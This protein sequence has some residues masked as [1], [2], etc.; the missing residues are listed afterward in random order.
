[1]T[2]R[3][4]TGADL[5]SAKGV[6]KS[7][8]ADSLT[9][10]IGFTVPPQGQTPE[11]VQKSGPADSRSLGRFTVRYWRARVY[12]PN[13]RDESGATREVEAWWLQVAHAGRRHAISLGTPNRDEAATRALRLYRLLKTEGWDAVLSAFKPDAVA[14]ERAEAGLTVGRWIELAEA[15]A[16]CPPR[17]AGNYA[18]ALRR[19]AADIA[20]AAPARG[21]S[22]FDP[23]GIWRAE[24]DKVPLAA[25]TPVAVE[26]WRLAFVKPHRGNPV[27]EARATRSVN[28]YLR[29]ARALF[30]RRIIEALRT[31]H[32]TL[33]EPL[34]FAGLRLDAKLGSTR[35]RSTVDAAALL[36]AARADLAERDPD[37]Y[38]VILLALG[39]GLRR[40]EIDAL[41][42]QAVMPERG[43]VRVQTTAQRRTKSAESEGDVVCDAG[44]FA[45]LARTRRPSSTLY[46]I[47]PDTDHRPSQA[48]QFYRAAD[49]FRRVTAWLRAN[50]VAGD[51]PLHTL[52]KEF[53]SAVADAG[54]IHQAMLQLRHAQISTTEAFYADRRNRATVGVAAILGDAQRQAVP[55]AGLRR[56]EA[57]MAAQA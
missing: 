45:E 25:L 4:T 42:W 13:Y 54:D 6:Q 41:Q 17:T 21:K 11:E 9:A 19:I 49:S 52:R 48:A 32:V 53:G 24:A 40:S 43:I 15:Y 20:Q 5:P 1:M 26:D 10:A 39:A 47:E 28:S 3:K 56:A 57:A 44:L 51:R 8:P 36:R 30:S 31:R 46:V 33:P 27:G 18:Y 23:S 22:R 50:G 37:A 34:P 38:A 7:K 12:R 2:Q 14:R 16:P 55:A 35:Y 29:N